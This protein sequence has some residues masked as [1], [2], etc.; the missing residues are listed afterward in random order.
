MFTNPFIKKE[1]K[2]VIC[3]G[4]G[5][6]MPSAVL[7]KLKDEKVA[8]TVVSA[9]L[10]SGG[11]SGK[12]RKE[13]NVL[14]FGDLR[15]AFIELSTFDSFTKK[16]LNHRFQSGELKGHNLGNLFMLSVYE[17]AGKS[18][19]EMFRRVNGY[20]KDDF[21][22]YP[23]TAFASSQLNAI[24]E[25]GEHVVGE[26]NIDVPKHDPELKIKK[27]FLSPEANICSYAGEEIEK[28][29]AIIIGPG[30][31]YSS[32]VQI[33]LVDGFA[34]AVKKSKAKLIYVC[35]VMNKN[36]ESNGFTVKD[37]ALEIEKYLKK[38]LD[39]VIYNN[40]R[41]VKSQKDNPELISMVEIDQ[42]L[43]DRYIGR[44]LAVSESNPMHSPKVLVSTIMDLIR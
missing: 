37:F 18:Y 4:G 19:G 15:R 17:T 44:E 34:E 36:G 10:D 5:N 21:K 27:L 41:V 35:N 43:D 31:I 39:Y 22:I 20:L 7:S 14:S 3:I 9:V 11:S 1:K 13:Y 25:N 32:L 6:A 30:D 8:I 23:S 42:D 24:L 2:R 28:A 16:V 33:L 38:R 12:L 40:R 26:T 29:D